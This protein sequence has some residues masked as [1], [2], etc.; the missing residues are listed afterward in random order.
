MLV[1]S[2]KFKIEGHVVVRYSDTGEILVDQHNDIHLKNFCDSMAESLANFNTGFIE[3]LHFGNGGSVVTSTGSVLY[4]APNVTT[5]DASLHNPTYFKVVND[6]SA[7]FN[8][9]QEKN[10][11]RIE[12]VFT[13][14]YTDIITT[15]TLGF[16]EPA[17]QL[18]F[19]NATST[20]GEFTF[21]EMGLMTAGGKRL[22]TH[23][24]FH[25]VQKALNRSIEI[26]Y[27]VRITVAA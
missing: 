19:D 27:T 11:I 26:I 17:G 25:P 10:N 13:N 16:G 20:E 18:A 15:C 9:D 4:S 12:S 7:N 24:V 14:P 22:L 6:R 8:D 1:D 3:E 5:P 23:V 21:D 2:T